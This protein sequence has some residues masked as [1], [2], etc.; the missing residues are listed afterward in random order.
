MS[1]TRTF[2]FRS[3]LVTSTVSPIT[4]NA[5]NNR[6][7]LILVDLATIVILTEYNR[8]H[9]YILRE[10]RRSRR[11]NTGVRTIPERLIRYACNYAQWMDNNRGSRDVTRLS[12]VISVFPIY[13]LQYFLFL[14]VVKRIVPVAPSIDRSMD[15]RRD[16]AQLELSAE[17][18][19][20][21]DTTGEDRS[22][23]SRGICVFVVSTRSGA[24]GVARITRSRGR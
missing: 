16:R 18:S 10:N 1:T 21:G 11:R 14:R 19:G 12:I 6:S 7:Y 17:T 3:S 2:V 20:S 9:E 22:A 5:A 13:N 4:R 24:R 23:D 8:I 15:P